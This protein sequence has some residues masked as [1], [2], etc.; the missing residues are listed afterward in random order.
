M[1]KRLALLLTLT[2]VAGMFSGC[3]GKSGDEVTTAS[4]ST[5]ETKNTGETKNN[6]ETK[7]ASEQEENEATTVTLWHM[8]PE[9][10]EET[11]MHKRLLAWAEEFNATNTDNITVEVSG[12]KTNDVILTTIA[13]GSTPDIFQ[14]FWNN[15]S[16][17]ADVGALYD[18]TDF[19]AS[20]DDKYDWD[21]NDFASNV[22]NLCTYNDS[23]YSIPF[24]F[25]STFIFYREDLLKE[26]GWDHFPETMEELA[27]C[28]RDC[29]ILD[30][31]GNITQ[32]GMIPDF[33]WQ[34][35]V[36]WPVAFG[37]TYMDEST[38]TITFDSEETI[39]A[40]QFQADI[41]AEYGYDKVKG[42][43]SG[44]GAR[45]TAEDPLLTGAVAMR[46]QSDSGFAAFDE[47]GVDIDWAVATVPGGRGMFSGGVFEVNANTENVDATLAVLASL[48]SE[49]AMKT[50]SE[51][52]F[53]K[54][55]FYARTSALE[56]VRDVLDVS[57]SAKEIA[58]LLLNSELHCFPM[59][60]YL[61]E[62]LGII[63]SEMS[64]AIAGDITVEEACKN[65]VKSVQPLADAAAK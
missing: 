25:S 8:W 4:E 5:Q 30:D 1:K 41:Y 36:F 54:G 15:A 19:V 39:A 52:E 24:T 6:E 38:N 7:T 23:I 65:V 20:A 13:S 33:P 43:Q 44:L 55:T 45:A 37:A 42:Y 49:E 12:G 57:D 56:N 2:M 26:A 51:G 27:Q 60:S 18:L 40:Y 53:G 17:W 31:K 10:E 46:W 47:Y 22:W 16:T 61:N 62:F 9:D 64:E 35:D 50:F 3:S 11:K 59:S 21:V 63:A 32:M 14:N 29:T 48:T 28:I 58:D 34:D